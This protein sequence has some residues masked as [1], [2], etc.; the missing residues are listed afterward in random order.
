M[1]RLTDQSPKR[2]LTLKMNRSKIYFHLNRCALFMYN[3]LYYQCIHVCCGSV[4]FPFVLGNDNN[5]MYM[6]DSEFETKKKRK[7]KPRIK[8]NH[9]IYNMLVYVTIQII[10]RLKFFN[11]HLFSISF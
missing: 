11:L 10:F 9:N 5:I 8:L 2:C 7:F 3:Y 1:I 6:Y 4:L